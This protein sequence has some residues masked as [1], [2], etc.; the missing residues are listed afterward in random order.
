M[1]KEI[2]AKTGMD[3]MYLA[4]EVVSVHG[5]WKIP[6]MEQTAMSGK[7]VAQEIFDYLR[8]IQKLNNLLIISVIIRILE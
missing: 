3:G 5:R 1:R 6:T 8:D 7:Q 4:G 2:E